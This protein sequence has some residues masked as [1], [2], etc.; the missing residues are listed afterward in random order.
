MSLPL[1]SAEGKGPTVR[2]LTQKSSPG[3]GVRQ[4]AQV[5]EAKDPCASISFEAGMPDAEIQTKAECCCLPG[6]CTAPDHDLW[7]WQSPRKSHSPQ[8]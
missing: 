4:T 6:G 7:A 5:A 3:E 2:R 1:W 8:G